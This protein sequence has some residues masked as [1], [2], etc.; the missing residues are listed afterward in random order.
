MGMGGFLQGLRGEEGA[1]IRKHVGEGSGWCDREE[2]LRLPKG[3]YW[4]V[5]DYLRENLCFHGGLS[6]RQISLHQSSWWENSIREEWVKV[7]PGELGVSTGWGAG[8]RVFP[9][10]L[11]V[12]RVFYRR[13]V[14]WSSARACTRKD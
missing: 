12:G 14:G 8:G 2:S 7:S 3:I 1:T 11:V 9:R 4:K 6:G 13:S 10:G 5:R